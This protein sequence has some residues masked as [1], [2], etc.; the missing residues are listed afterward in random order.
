MSGIVDVS[1]QGELLEAV[2]DSQRYN[3]ELRSG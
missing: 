3:D 2:D 1:E